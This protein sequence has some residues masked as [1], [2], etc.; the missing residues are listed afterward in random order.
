MFKRIKN[1][2]DI[3]KYSVEEVVNPMAKL[4]TETT[5]E[6]YERTWG[7]PQITSTDPNF[8]LKLNYIPR[9]ATIINL[10]DEDPFSEITNDTP[11]QPPSDTTSRN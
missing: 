5:E 9:P 11:E 10:K 7:E 8:E 1:L 4:P 6:Y 2:L 3:S